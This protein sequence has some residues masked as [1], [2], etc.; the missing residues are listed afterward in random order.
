[1]GGIRDYLKSTA[2]IHRT[3]EN[4]ARQRSEALI[5]ERL[6]IR[7]LFRKSNLLLQWLTVFPLSLLLISGNKGN[8]IVFFLYL[9]Y[10]L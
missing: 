6:Y 8:D 5:A 2:S 3:P 10:C 7:T 1:M 4:W 9:E